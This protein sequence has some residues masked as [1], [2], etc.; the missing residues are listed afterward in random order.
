MVGTPKIYLIIARGKSI[1]EG[2]LVGR[3][4]SGVGMSSQAA[5]LL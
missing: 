3:V 5:Y 1:L 4:D 2:E